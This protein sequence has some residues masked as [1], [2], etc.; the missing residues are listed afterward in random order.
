MLRGWDD[1][2]S[3]PSFGL[4]VDHRQQGKGTGCALLKFAMAAAIRDGSSAIRLSTYASNLRGIAVY[5]KFGFVET[6]RHAVTLAGRD[7]EKITMMKA[8]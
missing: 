4:F 6:E 8:L 2:F 1:G 3:I 7:Q 5:T